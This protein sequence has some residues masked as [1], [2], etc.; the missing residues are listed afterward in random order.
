MLFI[1]VS[2]RDRENRAQKDTV[3]SEQIILIQRAIHLCGADAV[4]C[5]AQLNARPEIREN[6]HR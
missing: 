5:R 4:R 6:R 1:S 2:F 3:A